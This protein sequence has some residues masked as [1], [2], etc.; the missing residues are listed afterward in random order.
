MNRLLFGTTILLSSAP[1]FAYVG[2][3]AGLGVL[4]TLFGI[5]AAI[6]LALFGLFWYPIKRV[7]KKNSATVEGD[8]IESDAP[9]D[10]HQE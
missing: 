8:N 9:P 10:D 3:G 2:P 6:I 4:G 5:F 1:A 7:L